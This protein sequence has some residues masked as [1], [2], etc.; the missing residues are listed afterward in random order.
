MRTPAIF[1][2]LDKTGCGIE[3]VMLW[4][5]A[6][7]LVYVFVYFVSIQQNVIEVSFET[8]ALGDF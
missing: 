2:G 4:L 8:V 6:C 7:L 1:V 5:L 3:K